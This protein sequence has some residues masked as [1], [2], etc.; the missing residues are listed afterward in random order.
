MYIISDFCWTNKM[1]GK[2]GCTCIFIMVQNALPFW[3]GVN[4]AEPELVHFLGRPREKRKSETGTKESQGTTG[5]SSNR[6]WLVVKLR[7]MPTSANRVRM[8]LLSGGGPANC[9]DG[10]GRAS[11]RRCRRTGPVCVCKHQSWGSGDVF[12]N[13][14]DHPEGLATSD[15]PNGKLSESVSVLEIGIYFIIPL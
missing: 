2:T 11:D 3:A 7:E 6:P 5:S 1:K 4:R 15:G 13:A 9:H 12:Q 10:G 8:S 14:L